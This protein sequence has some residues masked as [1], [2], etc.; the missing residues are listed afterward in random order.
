MTTFE[1]GINT[2]MVENINPELAH[3]ELTGQL[4]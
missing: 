4:L 2:A 1:N 3:F